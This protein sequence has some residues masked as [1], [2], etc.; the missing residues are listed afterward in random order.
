MTKELSNNMTK[1]RLTIEIRAIMEITTDLSAGI[2][3]RPL[4]MAA[5][6]AVFHP[7]HRGIT[8]EVKLTEAILNKT[9][10][11][12]KTTSQVFIQLREQ[13]ISKTLKID[14]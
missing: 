4:S 9:K 10:I 7:C 11:T 2:I 13:S 12:I 8:L 14:R 5:P 3:V 6:Q 1:I